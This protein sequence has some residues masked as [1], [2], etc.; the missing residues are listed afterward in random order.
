M[1]NWLSKA[2]ELFI[3]FLIIIF[4]IDTFSSTALY[5]DGMVICFITL[6]YYL[7]RFRLERIEKKIDSLEKPEVEHHYVVDRSTKRY[8]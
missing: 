1:N 6:V 7:T 2:G 3:V 4:S 8:G 5:D